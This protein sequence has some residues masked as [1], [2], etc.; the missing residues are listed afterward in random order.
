MGTGLTCLG[1]LWALLSLVAAIGASAGLFIPK[2]IEGWIVVDG[3]TAQTSFG[4]FRRC[5]YPQLDG[6]ESKLMLVRECG[7]YRTFADIPSL[8]W[9]ITTVTVAVGAAAAVLVAFVSLPAC[10]CKDIISRTSGRLLGVL[11]VVGGRFFLSVF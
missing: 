8:W 4:S 5:T 11:Q 10:I 1:Y 7:R 9:Q 6:K 2:W 3:E